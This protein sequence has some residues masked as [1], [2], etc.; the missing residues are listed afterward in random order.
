MQARL[1]RLCQLIQALRT[2]RRGVAVSA[3]VEVTESSRATVYRDLRVLQSAGLLIERETVNGEARHRLLDES[4]AVRGLPQPQI[5]AIALARDALSGLEGTELVAELD[6]ILSDRR[7]PAIPI[8]ARDPGGPRSP[9]IVR[10]VERALRE[11]LRVRLLYRGV[12]DAEPRWREVDPG[13]LQLQS[14]GA[15]Y[16]WCWPLDR[17]EWRTFKIARVRQ[18][19]PLATPAVPHLGL[20]DV[21]A[22]PHAVCVWSGE[23]ERVAVR[24]APQ[25]AWLA[26]EFPLVPDQ[27]IEEQPD[28]SVVV[29]ATVAG[30]VEASRW[31]LRWGRNACVLEPPELRDAIREELRQALVGYDDRV[32]S[33]IVRPAAGKPSPTPK[34]A[35]RRQ[36]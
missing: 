27:R 6:R 22:L 14:G 8:R 29:R 16:L 7:A 31:V 19:E 32:V 11:R 17:G 5:A 3:L 30:L 9:A 2:A 15:L 18:A 34:A 23:P 28:R 35:K 20:A 36:A 13:A 4:M 21:M 26:R 24:I 25:V 12:K 10:V 1:V 33:P